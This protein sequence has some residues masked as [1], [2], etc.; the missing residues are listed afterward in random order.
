MTSGG[1]VPGGRPRTAGLHHCRDLGKRRLNVG[2][3]TEEDLDHAHAVHRLR[4]DVL[5]VVD[6]NRNAAF[7]VGDDAVGHLAGRE[8]GEIPHHADNWNVD[9]GKDVDGS[10][11]NDDRRQDEEHQ[12]HHDEGIRAPERKCNNPHRSKPTPIGEPGRVTRHIC[13]RCRD[14]YTIRYGTYWIQY[15]LSWLMRQTAS[16]QE[17]GDRTMGPN[18]CPDGREASTRARQFSAAR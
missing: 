4:F 7:G 9:V 10:A 17:A 8:P 13:H 2:L 18:V 15:M 14:N 16:G 6:R 5:D 12:R 11:Q 1:V 3:R